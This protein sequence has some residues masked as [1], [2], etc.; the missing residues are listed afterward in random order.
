VAG[1]PDPVL[2][3]FAELGLCRLQVGHCL[4]SF[5]DRTHQYYVAEAIRR[6]SKSKNR[7]GGQVLHSQVVYCGT[8]VPRVASLCE[9]V[10]TGPQELTI[11]P[12]P[13]AGLTS[14]NLPV[15]VVPNLDLDSRF[16]H[17]VEK[18]QL[19]YAGVPIRS[20]NGVNIGVCC[21]MDDKARPEGLSEDQIRVLREVSETV[22]KHLE[23]KRYGLCNR[24]SE[25][26]LRG[27][28]SF[29][30]GQAT[31]SAWSDSHNQFFQDKAGE[32]AGTLNEKPQA[33]LASSPRTTGDF[34][35][36]REPSQN[37]STQKRPGLKR[38]VSDR[39]ARLTSDSQLEADVEM[40]VS[41]GS[42]IIREA[43]E[44]EG[45]LILDARSL[46]DQEVSEHEYS[47]E[48]SSVQSENAICR[49][50]GFSTSSSS[51]ING[52]L[53][54]PHLA[55]ISED[56]THKFLRYHPRGRIFC[57]EAEG[58]VSDL[59]RVEDMNE[60]SPVA[61]WRQHQQRSYF[62]SIENPKPTEFSEQG[63]KCREMVSG[64][65]EIF[66]GAKSVAFVPLWDEQRRGW[67]AGMFIWTRT[68]RRIFTVENEL[69]H[70]R[71]F[72]LTIMAEITRLNIRSADKTKT[73]I[74]G[75]ISHELR[76]PL[77]ALVGHIDLLR[78]TRLERNQ[79]VMA[80]AID[81]SGRTL[82]DTIEHV[83]DTPPSPFPIRSAC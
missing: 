62:E 28:A 45:V 11:L 47:S 55:S 70:L 23:T 60:S 82:L 29:V 73:N 12:E 17:I 42:N 66:T 7:D 75:S 74:L 19:F 18:G 24:R 6:P 57:L 54:P 13:A 43:A 8:K 69:S 72:S 4:I 35:G 21:V 83:R 37:Q 34:Q 80:H 14:A 44:V 71:V 41:R 65:Q 3:R 5:F 50:L 25:R 51:S 46:I 59:C 22:M 63:L 81:S 39:P 56:I 76:S 31:L 52:D 16:D 9:H 49:I 58:T 30:D 53:P 26:I 15:S 67:F 32:K 64:L 2:T 79:E 40:V 20:P 38:S 1:S 48:V 61:C 78:S 33:S 68:P 10:L 27:L 36:R 77:H